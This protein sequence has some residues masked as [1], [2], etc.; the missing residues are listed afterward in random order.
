MIYT[1][2]A[3]KQ[4]QKEFIDNFPPFKLVSFQNLNTSLHER[5]YEEPPVKLAPFTFKTPKWLRM[6]SWFLNWMTYLKNC[7]LGDEV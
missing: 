6:V 3:F 1:L 5:S 2:C 4:V 7:L